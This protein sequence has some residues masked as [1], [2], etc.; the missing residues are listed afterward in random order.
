[1]LGKYFNKRKNHVFHGVFMEFFCRT[2][3]Q[4]AARLTCQLTLLTPNLPEIMFSQ[5]AEC[6]WLVILVAEF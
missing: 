1:M 2:S 6:Y 5:K 4:K 3:D